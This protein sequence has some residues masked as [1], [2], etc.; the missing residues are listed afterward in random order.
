MDPPARPRLSAV[1]PLKLSGRHYGHNLG[2]CD[3]LFESFRHFGLSDVFDEILIIVPGAEMSE[4]A[5]TASRW[6]DLGVSVLAEEDAFPILR[7]YTRAHQVRPWHRQQYIKLATVAT[8]ARNRFVLT[9]DPDVF[10]IK[11]ITVDDL[12]IDGRA[13][14]E[15][16]DREVH[17]QWWAHSADLLGLDPGFGRPGMNVTPAILVKD[18]VAAL[19]ARLEQRYGRSWDDVLL[20]SNN[21]WTEYTLYYLTLEQMPDR[22]LL[23]VTPDESGRTTRLL[24]DVNIWTHEEWNASDFSEFFA[25]TNPGL[26]AVVQSWLKLDPQELARRLSPWVPVT[27]GPY[28]PTTATMVRIR[29]RYGSA[30]RQLIR[31]G[32][33]VQSRISKGG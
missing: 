32:R 3:L 19:A 10:A 15:P 1:L 31:M 30:V 11:P 21:M 18:V 7:S 16:E 25:P 27:I 8:L 33:R 6:A 14:L 9:L 12:I 29:E 23:H 5:H 28:R 2:Y 20:T 26:F 17:Q 24:S 22:E 13:L 4:V